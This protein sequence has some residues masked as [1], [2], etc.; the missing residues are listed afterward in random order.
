METIVL[1][2]YH[3]LSRQR[4]A[5]LKKYCYIWLKKDLGSSILFLS[6]VCCFDAASVALVL[7]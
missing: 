4:W 2:E 7:K 6:R 5:A 1:Y 3:C